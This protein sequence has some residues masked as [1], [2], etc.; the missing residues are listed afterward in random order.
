VLSEEDIEK[1][2][3]AFMAFDFKDRK[4]LGIVEVRRLLEGSFIKLFKN[5]GRYWLA[6]NRGI[7]IPDD[8]FQCTIRKIR[9]R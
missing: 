7:D 2:R 5:L 4:K 9:N 8:K 1:C 6:A 3:L